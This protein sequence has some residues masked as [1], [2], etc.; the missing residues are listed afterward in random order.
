MVGFLLSDVPFFCDIPL[1]CDAIWSCLSYR[2]EW[3]KPHEIHGAFLC[4]KMH[5]LMVWQRRYCQP[6][7]G[8]CMEESGNLCILLQGRHEYIECQGQLHAATHG[9]CNRTAKGGWS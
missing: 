3:I 7:R 5:R 6:R 2:Y 8:I 4:L 1:V 9:I